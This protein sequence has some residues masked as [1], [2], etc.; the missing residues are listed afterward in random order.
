MSTV[1]GE[2]IALLRQGSSL[3]GVES[4]RQALTHNLSEDLLATELH[5]F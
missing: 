5:W 3:R 1:P 4:Q 2:A